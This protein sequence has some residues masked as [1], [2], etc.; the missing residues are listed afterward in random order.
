MQ[1]LKLVPKVYLWN[2]T[3]KRPGPELRVDF[4]IPC[5]GRELISRFTDEGMHRMFEHMDD[6]AFAA[7]LCIGSAGNGSRGATERFFRVFERIQAA[8]V[9]VNEEENSLATSY[10]EEVSPLVASF[11][12]TSIGTTAPLPIELET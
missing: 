6:M 3:K 10:K 12:V 1:T 7:E 4:R 5:A 8:V 2:R 9:M 11:V